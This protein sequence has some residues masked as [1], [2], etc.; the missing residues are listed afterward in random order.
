MHNDIVMYESGYH[1][2]EIIM[3]IVVFTAFE[4]VSMLV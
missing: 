1:V 2:K 4:L 3:S